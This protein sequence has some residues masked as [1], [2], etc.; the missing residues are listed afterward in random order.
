MKL[1]IAASIVLALSGCA[2]KWE[3][4]ADSNQCVATQE[5]MRKPVTEFGSVGSF[6]GPTSVPVQTTRVHVKTYRLYQ[7]SNGSIWGPV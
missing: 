5:T 1:L 3:G 7:C 4:Y 2:S 6:T